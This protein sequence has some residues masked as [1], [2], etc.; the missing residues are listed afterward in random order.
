LSQ[1]LEEFVKSGEKTRSGRAQRPELLP[2]S[3]LHVA[4]L[5]DRLRRDE[6]AQLD[7]AGAY[8]A[9]VFSGNLRSS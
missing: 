3:A 5:R 2:Q 6:F 9:F 7:E 8:D 1:L 4:T